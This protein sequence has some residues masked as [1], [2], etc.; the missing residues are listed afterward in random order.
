[1][2]HHSNAY[3]D[4]IGFPLLNDIDTV[5]PVTC[6]FDDV[7][8]SPLLYVE[9][10]GLS[11]HDIPSDTFSRTDMLALNFYNPAL[12]S[13]GDMYVEGLGIATLRDVSEG[14][15]VPLPAP[16]AQ[17]AAAAG[18]LVVAGRRKRAKA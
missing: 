16:A 2:F 5:T 14:R 13:S 15:I 10:A 18:L 11:L 9:M 6:L 12:S 17:L 8:C 1:M 3:Y 7:A 4:Y